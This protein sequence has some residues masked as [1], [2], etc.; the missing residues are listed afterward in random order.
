MGAYTYDNFKDYVKV[1]F[2]GNDAWDDYYGIFVNSA[3]RQ[4]T[5][6]DKILGTRLE[7]PELET[8]TSSNTSDGTAYISVPADCLNIIEIYDT[9]NDIHLEWLAHPEYISK[10][11]RD[12]TTAEGNSTYWV[13]SGGYIWLYPTPDGT[14][15]LTIHY[16]K[17]PADLSGDS[18]VTVLGEEWDDVILELAVAIGRDWANEPE[19]ALYSRKMAESM[20]KDIMDVYNREEKAR[21]DGLHPDSAW[22]N[23]STY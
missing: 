9:T 10:S 21:R 2:G 8:T 5:S 22:S 7:I 1:R 12:D 15:A 19:K 14:H 17:R 13:R 18:D 16:R 4:L 20:A 6:R 11:D 23:K 3:Y